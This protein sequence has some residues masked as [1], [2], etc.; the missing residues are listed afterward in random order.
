[1]ILSH[2]VRLSQYRLHRGWSQAHLAEQSGVSRTEISAIENGRLVPSVAVAMRLA[3]TLGESVESLFGGADARESVPWAWAPPTVDDSRLW[4]ATVSGRLLAYAVEPTAAG[5]LPH[6]ATASGGG[7]EVIGTSRPDRTLVVAGCDPLVGM[8]VQEMAERHG[9]RVLPLLRSSS[10]ALDL[11]QKGLVHVAGVHLTDRRGESANEQA[12]RSRLGGG[13][14]LIHQ[15]RWDAGIAI[16]GGRSER[17]LRALLR[18]NIRW[19]NREEG[20]A[21]RETFDRLLGPAQRPK[22]YQQIAR[23]HRAIAEA[24]SAGWAEAGVC[25]RPAAAEA[26][27]SFITLN[28]EAYE[29]CV[30]EKSLDDPRLVA[31]TATLRSRR[32]RQLLAD[33]PGCE[34]TDTGEQR[35]VA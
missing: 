22:G 26:R 20:S 17:T 14:V 1:M 12:V 23:G 8:L 5:I 21:A 33:V 28:R 2:S 34:S 27:L 10:E 31:L 3:A 13:H 6:D 29:L 35:V 19:V 15:L 7:M 32:Y 18:A 30:V 24:V 4:R 16:G 11:L 25:I 9:I